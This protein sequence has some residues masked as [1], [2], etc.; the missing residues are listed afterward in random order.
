MM[1][2]RTAAAGIRVV[3]SRYASQTD[4]VRCFHPALSIVIKPHERPHLRHAS[5]SAYN[6][7]RFLCSST[8][9][10]DKE[11]NETSTKEATTLQIPGTVLRGSGKQLAI[12]YTCGVCETRSIKQFTERA[13][14][15]GVVIV[16]C[17]GCSRQHLIADRLGYFD[18]NWDIQKIVQ[19]QGG[20]DAKFESVLEVDLEDFLGKEKFGQLLQQQQ[21]KSE[22]SNGET[23]NL[24][25]EKRVS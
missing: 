10:S 21:H 14:L 4:L 13:Y 1:L 19:E 9:S 20:G 6:G 15:Q 23:S 18:D 16:R 7:K 8:S 11:L 12:V 22:A 3:A 2:S 24:S 17:P 25:N 5:C